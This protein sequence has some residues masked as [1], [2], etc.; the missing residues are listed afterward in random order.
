VRREF[1]AS[2]TRRFRALRGIPD[3][4]VVIPGEYLE[5]VVPNFAQKFQASLPFTAWSSTA[6]AN[7]PR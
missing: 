5:V 7:R 1:N 3:G 6:L 2:L 4:A